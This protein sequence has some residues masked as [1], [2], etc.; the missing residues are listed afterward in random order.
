LELPTAEE[1]LMTLHNLWARFDEEDYLVLLETGIN[2]GFHVV[3][4]GLEI[5]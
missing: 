2:A 4:E 3:A 5:T 1:R